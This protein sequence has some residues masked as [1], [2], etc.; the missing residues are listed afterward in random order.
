MVLRYS[1]RLG[2]DTLYLMGIS[3][4]TSIAVNLPNHVTLPSFRKTLGFASKTLDRLCPLSTNFGTPLRHSKAD[5]TFTAGTGLL[6]VTE[7]GWEI[8]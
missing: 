8:H 2:R 7:N 1:T 5:V 4:S 6:M 3:N